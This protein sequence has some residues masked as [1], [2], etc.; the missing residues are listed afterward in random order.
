MTKTHNTAK[1]LAIC[2]SC[3]F[4]GHNDNSGSSPTGFGGNGFAFS[5]DFGWVCSFVG[6]VCPIAT[7]EED[8][9]KNTKANLATKEINFLLLFKLLGLTAPKHSK[10]TIFCR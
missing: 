9:R 8:R 5:L 1:K 4:S 7:D 6:L 3:Y 2:S 10:Y